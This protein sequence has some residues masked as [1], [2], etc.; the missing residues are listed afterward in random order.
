MDLTLAGS[1]DRRLVSMGSTWRYYAAAGAPAEDWKSVSYADEAWSEGEAPLGY[2]IEG[3]TTAVPFGLD[4]AQKFPTTWYRHTFTVTDQA[5]I[6]ALVLETV[7]SDAAV[8]YLNGVE[9]W[10]INLLQTP[11]EATAYAASPV[12]TGW[13]ERPA[14]TFIDPGLVVEGTNTLA[15]EVHNAA[16]DTVD[17]IF[18]LALIP[19]P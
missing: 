19:L 9:V 17:H 14:S 16:G 6:E 3:V 18:D 8:V 2:G 12:P 7:R 5:A 15:V 10:R 1:T 11:V 13:K 4:P